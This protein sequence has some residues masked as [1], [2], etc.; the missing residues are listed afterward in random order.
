MAGNPMPSLVISGE[1]DRENPPVVGNRVQP[2]YTNSNSGREDSMKKV[3]TTFSGLLHERLGLD[4]LFSLKAWQA[5]VAELVGTGALVFTLEAIAIS[6]TE[7]QIGSPHLVI[8]ALISILVTVLI[9][10]T[11]PVSG[12]HLNPAI[13]LSAALVGRITAARAAIY[14]AMQCLGGFLATLA[15][16]AAVAREV[17]REFSLGGCG[18]GQAEAR[19]ALWLETVCT[20]VLLLSVTVVF[21]EGRAGAMAHGPVTVSAVIGTTVGLMVYVSATVTGRKGYSGVGLNAARCFGPAVVGGGDLWTAHWVFWV[22][23]IL[24]SMGMYVYVKA[25]PRQNSHV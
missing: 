1:S 18:L 8:A 20:F 4:E 22:G 5:S 7:A 16:K 23:P 13:S 6:S 10:V 25:L 21:N 3:P 2:F 12:G 9:L 11:G 17:A 14:V 15:L 24:A 19:P